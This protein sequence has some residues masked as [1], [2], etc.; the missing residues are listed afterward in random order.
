MGQADCIRHSPERYFPHRPLLAPSKVLTVSS[1]FPPSPGNDPFSNFPP[2]ANQGFGAPQFGGQHFGNSVYGQPPPQASLSLAALFSLLAS[3]AS[4]FFI[5]A[6]LPYL[7]P[8]VALTGIVLG[9]VALVKISRSR[10]TLSG[11]GL[12]IG[13]LVLGYPVLLLGLMFSALVFLPKPQ[14]VPVAKPLDPNSPSER[15]KAAERAISTDNAGIAHGN[16]KEAKAL[17][18]KYAKTMKTLREAF[19]TKSKGGL[20]MSGG[21]FVTYCELHDGR[22]AF[23]T[24]VPEYRKFE[25]SAKDSLAEIAWEAAQMTV[26][27]RLDEG[28]ELGVG[29]KGSLLYGKVMVGR[30]TIGGDEKR[31]LEH[32][33]KSEEE[34]L[35]PFFELEPEEMPKAPPIKLDE[36]G[37]S[38]KTGESAAAPTPE[39]KP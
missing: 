23:V 25:G 1:P 14:N 5:C 20:S 15:L 30:V 2:P 26:A 3:I 29:M 6:C 36:P 7:T 21:N 34:R 8:I 27:D 9:H 17:A 13:G 31:G 37:K 22:C 16:S 18:E 28:D 38:A 12:A 10:G 32:Q 4:P 11:G 39:P 35:E 19:F 24:H 33:S